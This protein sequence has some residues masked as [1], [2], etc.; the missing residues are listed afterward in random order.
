M[1]IQYI[2]HADF[3]MPGIIE[4]WAKQNSFKE[5]ICRPF[6]GEKLPGIDQFDFL[7]LMGGPQSPLN[8]KEAPYLQNEIDLI[9]KALKAE[10]PVLGFCLGAQL[11]G[12]AFGART[13]RSPYKEVGV[14]PIE[15]TDEGLKDHLLQELPKTFPVVHWHNDMPGLTQEAKIL[16]ASQGCPRQIIRYSELA[17]GFQCHPEPTKSNIE[18]MIHH[19]PNDLAPGKFV[20][21]ASELL[22]QDFNAI[23]QKMI[24]ILN[25]L[26]KI[27]AKR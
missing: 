24:I 2:I 27:S 1:K 13:E 17:Y 5:N 12:E 20:Q 9:R 4:T 14:F 21:T 7:I 19:C 8:M 11:I 22:A 25:N 23:N 10:M 26:I 16:A 18:T 3:E 6:A 15:L